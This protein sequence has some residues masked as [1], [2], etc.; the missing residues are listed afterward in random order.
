MGISYLVTHDSETLRLLFGDVY[1]SSNVGSEAGLI[2]PLS[3]HK[4][5]EFGDYARFNCTVHALPTK[6]NN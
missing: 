4:F 5:H 6:I 2:C 3:D 1:F